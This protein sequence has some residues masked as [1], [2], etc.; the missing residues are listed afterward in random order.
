[1]IAYVK[2]E[3]PYALAPAFTRHHL[4][5]FAAAGI[6]NFLWEPSFFV[7]PTQGTFIDFASRKHWL[8]FCGSAGTGHPRRVKI[9]NWLKT[10]LPDFTVFTGSRQ[11][12]GDI[13]RNSKLSL[14]VSL[15]SDFNM[16]CFEIIADGGLLVTDRLSKYSGFND[17]FVP[18]KHCL[19]FDSEEELLDMASSRYLLDQVAP[20][21]IENSYKLY[22]DRYEPTLAWSRL[23]DTVERGHFAPPIQWDDR[24]D[25][26]VARAQWLDVRIAIYEMAQELHRRHERVFVDL[27]PILVQL[28]GGDLDDLPRVFSLSKMDT[29][30]D[31]DAIFF[32]GMKNEKP[33]I[34]CTHSMHLQ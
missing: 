13:I 18:G 34:E 31:S 21:I 8:T 22:W 23:I 32:V 26:S 27:S 24:I 15:N 5:W 4:H 1:M 20:S 6:T 7:T 9:I 25:S 28:I 12:V 30:R 29:R 14:N 2:R 19:V 3:R 10:Q 17:V 11:E 16:R 33:T